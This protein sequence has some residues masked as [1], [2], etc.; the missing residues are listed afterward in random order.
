MAT[1]D[2]VANAVAERAAKMQAIVAAPLAARLVYCLPFPDT[3]PPL[4]GACQD[5]PDRVAVAVDIMRIAQG[6]LVLYR[7][8]RGWT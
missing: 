6:G 8:T 3:P 1:T 7:Q 2:W 5:A 4:H